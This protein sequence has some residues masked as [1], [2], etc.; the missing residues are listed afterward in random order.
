MWI[1]TSDVV[2]LA[3]LLVY[4]GAV[5]IDL[6]VLTAMALVGRHEFDAAMTVPV[7]VLIRNDA[8]HWLDSSLLAKG[9]LL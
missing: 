7:V 8:T 5:K 6:D 4:D 3:S 2:L 1:L 9:R